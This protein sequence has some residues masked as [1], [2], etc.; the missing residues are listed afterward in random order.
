M[1]KVL[2]ITP[3]FPPSNTADTHRVRMSLPYFEEFGWEA[4]VIS[5]DSVYSDTVKDPLLADSLHP[6]TRL[7]YVHA[8]SKKWTSKL[9]IGG[10]AFRSL[11]FFKKKVD[12]LLKKEHFNLIYFSTTE[13]PVMI[14]G[15][16][17]KIKYGIPFVADM[18]DP[19]HTDYYEDK[20]KS[21]RPKK[22]WLSYRLNRFLERVA[23]SKVDGLISVSQDYIRQLKERYP[24]IASIPA[25]T[26]TFGAFAKDIEI[27]RK[28]IAY[29]GLDPQ[30]IH[31]VY[32]GRGGYDMADSLSILFETFASL[33]STEPDMQKI[34]FH[35]IGTSYAP[36]GK[37]KPTI[38]PLAEKWGLETYVT[39]QTDR[40]PFYK[41]LS[42]L[43][44]ADALFVP[45]SN[46]PNYTAS[47]IFPYIMANKPMLA[48]FHSQSSA[49]EIITSCEAGT[50]AQTNHPETA[51][52]IVKNFLMDAAAR[53]FIIPATD[54]AIFERYSAKSM[55]MQQVQLFESVLNRQQN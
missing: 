12:E 49:G 45:G 44:Q 36:A 22:Y 53:K 34:R 23:L 47:K 6:Q 30:L 55:T 18:Q 32:V 13:F 11:Y 38:A 39:E 40:V 1:K 9:G 16:Y 43:L 52:E 42:L 4:T 28:N 24:A 21:E 33:L 17:I 54:Y 37:G 31:F 5:V 25:A 29:A 26:I 48:L 46:D 14:L 3:Y 8:L 19:W 7:I 20:P 51:A 41:G 27:A 10:L 15:P 50:V 2:I 35:F